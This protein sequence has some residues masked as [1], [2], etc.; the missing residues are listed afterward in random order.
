MALER[1]SRGEVRMRVAC[2]HDEPLVEGSHVLLAAGRVPNTDDLALQA[3]GIRTNAHGYVEVDDQCRASVDGV[4]A[5][6]DCNG[7]G[8]FTHTAWNDHEIV[9]DQLFGER[10]RGIGERPRCYALYTDP[11]L[12]RIG[13]TEDEVR[14]RGRP[15][16]VA[17]LPMRRVGRAKVSGET[18]G[19]MK[20]LVDA[21][22]QRIL[23]AAILGLHGDEV[24]HWLL[25]AMS[26]DLPCTALTR[27]VPIHPTVAELV[28]TL[29]QQARP[30]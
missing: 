25:G 20:V 28:P 4:W 11:P 3:A 26:A 1:G 2:E 23:G 24:I 10:S 14:A 19:M 13:L 7:R 16:L 29:L 18:R 21:Q 15:A 30:L 9:I 27:S 6:G 12:G 17:T 22:T 5:L 8:A